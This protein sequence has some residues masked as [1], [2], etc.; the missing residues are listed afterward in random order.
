M[1][2]REDYNMDKYRKDIPG[3]F[4]PLSGRRKGDKIIDSKGD[5]GLY[6]TSE[7]EVKFSKSGDYWTNIF[8]F[9]YCNNT[10]VGN[11][12]V[13]ATITTFLASYNLPVRCV[14]K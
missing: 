1:S 2:D 9:Y 8:R 4:F 5:D 11:V 10:Y 7:T 3:V 6:F 13:P 14:K 12:P